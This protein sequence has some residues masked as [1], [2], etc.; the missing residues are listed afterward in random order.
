MKYLSKILSITICLMTISACQVVTHH[1]GPETIGNLHEYQKKLVKGGDFWITTYQKVTDKTK[2][3]VFYIESDG[4]AFA[5]RYVVSTNPTP[6]QQ[7]MI[8]LVAMD[9]RPNV[10]YV[11]RPCQY[12]P[13]DLNPKCTNPYWTSKRLSDD[14]VDAVNQV[15]MSINNKKEFSLIGYSGGGGMAVLI[16]ARNPLVKDIITIAANL[17]HKAFTS[18]HNV[19]PMVGSLNP[20]D[21]AQKINKIPQMH[22]SGGKDRIIPPFIADKFVQESNSKCVKQHIFYENTHA[23]GWEK[24]W[25]YILSLPVVCYD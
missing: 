22:F 14:S 23:Y 12:T 5:G 1:N 13:M 6:R 16:A 21:Y 18:Y 7:M 3:F 10:V 24:K 19:T 17:D 4:A 11:A 9:K 15:I 25:K 2:P 8:K 20:I